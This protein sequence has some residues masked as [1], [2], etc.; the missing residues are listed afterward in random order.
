MAK[1][2][3]TLAS[4]ND[5]LGV[6]TRYIELSPKG[7]EVVSLG[8]A[9]W[10]VLAED[11]YAPLDVPPFDRSEVDGYAVLSD[12]VVGADDENPIKLRVVGVSKIGRPSLNTVGLGEAIEIDTGAVIPRGANSVVMVEHCR[13]DG[14]YVYV[15]RSVAPGENV[16]FAGSDIMIGDLVLGKGSLITPRELPLL[17]ALGISKVKVFRKPKVGLISIGSELRNPGEAL[18]YGEIYDVNT[19]SIYGLLREMYIE[20][21]I[22]GIVRDDFDAL[23][24]A[25]SR[26]LEENDIVITS[27]GTSAGVTDITYRV[28]NSLGSPGIIIHGIKVRPG[29]PTVIG[30]VDGKLVI[31]LPGFPLSAIMIFNVVVKPI[32]SRFLGLNSIPETKVKAQI[33]DRIV[34]SRG[35]EQLIPVAIVKDGELKAYPIPFTSG[36][37]SAI[38]RADG[39]IRVPEN[40]GVLESGTYV[41]VY[42]FSVGVNVPDMVFIGSHDY[43]VNLALTLLRS[44]PHVKVINVGSLAGILAIKRGEADISGIH[45]LDEESGQYNITF[46]RKFNI[47]SD[48]VLVKGYLRNVGLI[49]RRGNPKNIKGVEDLLRND[50]VF[51]NRNKG[52]GTRT[53][54][55]IMLRNLARKLGRDFLGIAKSIKG[56]SNEAKT[57]SAVAAAVAQ[58]RADVGLGIE[59]AARMYGLDFIPLH[60][61]EYDFL[62]RVDRMSKRCVREFIDILKSDD[63]R[64]ELS[65]LCGYEVPDD[66]GSIIKV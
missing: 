2:F 66:I 48:A 54:L 60:K 64:R 22:Y 15:Y 42:L 9:L 34:S 50:V 4:I 27:G 63:F 25:L 8:D 44:R 58:G 19:Y 1:V 36:T 62:V 65:K 41:D 23:S 29:K 49:V 53:L 39:F 59:A 57:H 16:S 52:S 56:Y 24:S 6:L 40:L 46:L 37:V 61:E 30:V 14:D 17:A 43:G 35:V 20:P 5:V 32:L 7:V 11:V 55:D 45:L 31:G 3:H 12:S 10:R 18:Y 21:T 28:I 38:S 47:A 26:A 13:R 51:I 33:S